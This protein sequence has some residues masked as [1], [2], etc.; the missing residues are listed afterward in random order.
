MASTLAYMEK[1]SG[2]LKGTPEKSSSPSSVHSVEPEDVAVD[3]KLEARVVRK[4]DRV[5]LTVFFFI[6][7]FRE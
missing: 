7:M 5:V 1:S 4:I 2:E 3:P 6:A